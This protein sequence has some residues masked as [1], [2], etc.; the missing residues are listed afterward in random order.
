[1]VIEIGDIVKHKLTQRIGVVKEFGE[2]IA[3]TKHREIYAL[4]LW[5]NSFHTESHPRLE[6]LEKIS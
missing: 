3:H 2:F 5:F 1:V 6:Y 4:V